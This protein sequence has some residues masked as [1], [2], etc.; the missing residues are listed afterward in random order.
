MIA[1][2][3]HKLEDGF[4]SGVTEGITCSV[5]EGYYT[6]DG[7]KCVSYGT[8]CHKCIIMYYDAGLLE[9]TELT[10]LIEHFKQKEITS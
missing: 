9:N 3:G 7:E 5:N 8:Y 1:T 4:G 6:I 10:K 2:C